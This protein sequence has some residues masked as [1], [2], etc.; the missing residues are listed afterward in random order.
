MGRALEE[1][2]QTTKWLKQ[3]KRKKRYPAK[4]RGERKK[5]RTGNKCLGDLKS[6]RVRMG[7][8]V[9]ITSNWKSLMPRG[10]HG[11]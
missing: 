5:I 3:N 9:C 4:I 7:Y 10:R 6:F 11:S 1:E 8:A 2:T